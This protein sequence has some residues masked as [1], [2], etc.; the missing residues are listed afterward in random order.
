MNKI[1][2]ILA[3]LLLCGSI[4][5][6]YADYSRKIQSIPKTG[7][8]KNQPQILGADK[9]IVTLDKE[10][11]H[12]DLN[13]P[14]ELTALATS[15]SVSLSWK[16][17]GEKIAINNPETAAFV[18]HSGFRIYRDGFWYNDIIAGLNTYTDTNLY[19]SETYTYS[20]SAL[21][22][23]HK[24]EGLPGE[25]V[26]VE[27]KS[28]DAKVL[29]NNKESYSTY[30]ATGDSVTEGHR[31]VKGNGWV[32]Q[33]A[34]HLKKNSPQIKVINAGTTGTTTTVLVKRMQTELDENKPDLVTIGVGINDLVA[35][36]ESENGG[37]KM[38]DVKNNL[39]KILDV[40][41][42]SKDRTVM[43]LNIYYQNCCDKD[44]TKN[45]G[46]DLI[47]NKMMRDIAYSKNIP[48]INV[49][50]PMKAA[51][52]EKSLSIDL[53]HPSQAGHDIIAE[54]V[55]EAFDLN[56]KTNSKQ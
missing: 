18:T 30:L 24:I 46:K 55:T 54:T 42:P 7:Q 40:A 12:S 2:V 37:F 53:L 22:F 41:A 52:A 10:K 8:D 33:F 36:A 39:E 23:D 3:F 49:Y 9:V 28:A 5:L 17:D 27:T 20:V 47:W 6:I 43:L 25:A 11:T 1:I 44:W 15:D 31:A 48:L 29:Q 13:A 56:E 38:F 32:D 19:P 35:G 21:T 51:G 34:Q 16:F 14:T 26:R 4:V 50:T 45:G